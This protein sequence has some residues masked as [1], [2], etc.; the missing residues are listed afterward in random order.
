MNKKDQ[1]LIYNHW[2]DIVHNCNLENILNNE[3]RKFAPIKDIMDHIRMVSLSCFAVK[4]FHFN[5]KT[6]E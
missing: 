4:K 1:N 6:G 3:S 2:E 5:I